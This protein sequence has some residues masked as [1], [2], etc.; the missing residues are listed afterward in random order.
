MINKIKPEWIFFMNDILLNN[1]FCKNLKYKEL[2][3]IC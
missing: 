1:L 3:F 2:I